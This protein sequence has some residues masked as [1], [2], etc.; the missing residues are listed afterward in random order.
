MVRSYLHIILWLVFTHALY[1]RA[2]QSQATMSFSGWFNTIS[3]SVTHAPHLWG[4]SA[5][6][7]HRHISPILRLSQLI[8]P[9]SKTKTLGITGHQLSNALCGHQCTGSSAVLPNCSSRS[10]CAHWVYPLTTIWTLV[11]FHATLSPIFACIYHV[12]HVLFISMKPMPYAI[13][14]YTLPPSAGPITG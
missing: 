7:L 13:L 1:V 11:V 10:P 2:G 8:P 6:W 9:F 3:M 14:P 5:Q 12:F 4:L